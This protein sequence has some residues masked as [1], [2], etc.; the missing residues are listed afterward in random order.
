M[1]IWCNRHSSFD[2]VNMLFSAS[3]FN[4]RLC[5]DKF[6]DFSGTSTRRGQCR[7]PHSSA[8]TGAARA[9]DLHLPKSSN[10]PLHLIWFDQNCFFYQWC[11][12]LCTIAVDSEGNVGV[13][14][15]LVPP[16]SCYGEYEDA[17]SFHTTRLLLVPFKN[18]LDNLLLCW[19]YTTE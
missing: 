8:S 18:V 5:F 7:G 15:V 6:L 4:A 2:H 12:W 13:Q 3:Q 19:V 10:H 17:A 1:G 11:S 9:S 16:I 14:F